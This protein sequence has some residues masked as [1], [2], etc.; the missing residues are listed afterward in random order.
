MSDGS[1]E[2]YGALKG[3]FENW[4]QDQ[5]IKQAIIV[6]RDDLVA[7]LKPG[8]RLSPTEQAAKLREFV[9][10]YP[11]FPAD[12]MEKDIGR[13][14][15]Q[16]FKEKPVS[17]GYD[18]DG[19]GKN[20]T[21][22]IVAHSRD[23]TKAEIAAGISGV[24]ADKLTGLPGTDKDWNVFVMAHEVGHAGQNNKD[25]QTSLSAEV[26]AD[27]SAIKYYAKGHAAGL[28]TS[29]D[30]PTAFINMRALG[31]FSPDKAGGMMT[32]FT[33]AAIRLNGEGVAPTLNDK[34]F[35]NAWVSISQTVA[36]EIGRGLVTD[37]E[38][39]GVLKNVIEEKGLIGMRMKSAGFS[40]SQQ[41]KD[42]LTDVINGKV[43]IQ[44][45]LGQLDPEVRA[46]I[47][48][49][50]T[51]PEI[52]AGFREFRDHPDLM[53]ETVRKMYLDGRFDSNPIGKQ[54][55]HEFLTAARKY[56]SDHF[57]V[58]DMKTQYEPPAFDKTGAAVGPK[59]E[60]AIHP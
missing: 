12:V 53:H 17:F 28:L 21:V 55:A 36:R 27:K 45:G 60:A 58:H 51:L 48:G 18:T 46:K 33:S 4:L 26:D 30:V 40:L 39:I 6:S 5:G 8:A 3:Q 25:N 20:D 59:P 37:Q 2:Y 38:R 11:G 15:R 14:S 32:H 35:G 52:A 19:D 23:K 54:Y 42:L 41:Q 13:L 31:A 47:Q 57:G 7:G 29:A 24:P 34:T 49:Y 50:M 9:G 22:V 43:P 16:V 44:E 56:A 10:Q 1:A